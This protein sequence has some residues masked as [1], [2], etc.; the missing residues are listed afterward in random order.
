MAFVRITHDYDIFYY[1][2][3][4]GA[5]ANGFIEGLSADINI[6]LKPE[7][8][9]HYYLTIKGFNNVCRNRGYFTV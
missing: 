3:N 6:F 8:I 7:R 2:H 5:L 4:K 1:C 9:R